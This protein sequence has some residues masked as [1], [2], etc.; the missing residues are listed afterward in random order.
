MFYRFLL[1][2]YF[3]KILPY[4]NQQQVFCFVFFLL[5][6]SYDNHYF[7]SSKLCFVFFT[8]NIYTYMRMTEW[9]E[10]RIYKFLIL[11]A[12]Q[13]KKKKKRKLW[14]FERIEEKVIKGSLNEWMNETNYITM[15][16]LLLSLL[17]DLKQ[18]YYLKKETKITFGKW[19][20]S[21][22]FVVIYNGV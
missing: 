10:V 12:K 17:L 14:D 7:E 6:I 11:F 4:H 19:S 9:T 8:F 2:W 5:Q 3:F 21:T 1:Y 16:T 20:K 15:L 18:I 13:K 22:F